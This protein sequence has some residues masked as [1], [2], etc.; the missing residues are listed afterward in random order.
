VLERWPTGRTSARFPD[1][2]EAGPGATAFVEDARADGERAW[3]ESGAHEI[4]LRTREGGGRLRLRAEGEGVLRVAGQTPLAIPAGGLEMDLPLEPIVH[5]Q[6][7]RG[8]TET[9]WRQRL[10]VEAPDAVALRLRALDAE[11]R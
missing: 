4:L 9:L 2:V 7:R 6:G 3:V 11:V 5:L 8:A 1:A 10:E